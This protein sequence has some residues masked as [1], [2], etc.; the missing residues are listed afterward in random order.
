L[1][2][3]I[4]DGKA[5]MTG[6]FGQLLEGRLSLIEYVHSKTARKRPRRGFHRVRAGEQQRIDIVH[7]MIPQVGAMNQGLKVNAQ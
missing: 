5:I 6:E 4:A 1:I 2:E 3:R 7:E